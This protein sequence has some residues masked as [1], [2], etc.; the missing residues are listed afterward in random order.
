MLDTVVGIR[1]THL[2][3]RPFADTSLAP[4]CDARVELG[5]LPSHAASS[6]DLR[7]AL[8][9]AST[10]RQ[11]AVLLVAY[12]SRRVGADTESRGDGAARILAG[13][14]AG[15]P[16]AVTAAE[17]AISPRQMHRRS[18]EMFGMPPT[19]L[20]RILRIH[21]AASVRVGGTEPTLATVAA[22]AGFS[23]QAHLARD[24]QALT[25]TT[26]SLALGR[27]RVAVSDSFKTSGSTRP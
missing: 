24:T 7:R 3:G 25:L 6:T 2:A 8:Q 9:M 27:G 20:R 15:E 26:S 22:E 4:W 14:A 21:R 16:V 12:A 5:H 11:Q 23:D 18:L 17:L 13:A 10:P 1:L 19:T